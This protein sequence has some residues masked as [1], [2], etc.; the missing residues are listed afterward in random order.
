MSQNIF[1]QASRDKL[2]YPATNG[3]INTED[4][5]DLSLEQLDTMAQKLNREVKNRSET[6]TSFIKASR[7]T[8]ED[9]LVKLRFD[10]VKHIIDVKLDERE[11]AEKQAEMKAKRQKLLDLIDKKKEEELGEK[12]VEE[13]KEELESLEA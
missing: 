1:E 3:Q 11:K 12:S 2:R 7:P 6:E 4:L 8:K 5:W 10:I 9:K 13:L